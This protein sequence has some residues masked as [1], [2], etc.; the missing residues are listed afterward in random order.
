M[1]TIIPIQRRPN[2]LSQ[3]DWLY[4]DNLRL[5]N[6]KRLWTRFLWWLLCLA[7]ADFYRMDRL[8]VGDDIKVINFS[9]GKMLE[10]LHLTKHEMR[11]LY[12]EEAKFIL[13]GHEM[14]HD[15]KMECEHML[16]F[17]MP[18]PIIFDGV[19]K[20]VGLNVVVCPWLSGVALVPELK[21]PDE[22]TLFKEYTS[23]DFNTLL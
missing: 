6:T 5:T 7:G 22:P 4:C 16:S 11:M 1:R 23:R 3:Y 19:Q 21:I 20:V 9:S 12:N 13:I 2:Y 18:Q 15:L 8:R 14:A 10:A 17:S